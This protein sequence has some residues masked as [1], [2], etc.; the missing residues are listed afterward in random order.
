MEENKEKNIEAN[1]E[2]SERLKNEYLQGWQRARA[3]LMNYKKEEMER[4][5]EIIKYANW[6][7]LLKLLPILD[8]FNIICKSLPE[9]LIKDEYVKGLLQ[10]K[11]QLEDFLKM[12]RIVEIKT[13][14]E[15]FDPNF[16]EAVEVVPIENQES[17]IIIEEVQRGYLLEGKLLRPAKVKISK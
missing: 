12:H 3:D 1:I 4:I 15:R 9:N 17:G 2:E 16:H 6:E 10:V 13:A 7:L 5:G 8:N 11:T 14:G